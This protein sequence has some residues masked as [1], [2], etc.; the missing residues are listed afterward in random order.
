MAPANMNRQR[1]S[2]IATY[3]A[4]LYKEGKYVN[5]DDFAPEYLRKS[6]AERVKEEKEGAI[7]EKAK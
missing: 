5:A 7:N 3:G 2:S 1:A 6:Q 4:I